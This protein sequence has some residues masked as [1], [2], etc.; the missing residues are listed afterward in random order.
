MSEKQPGAV[1]SRLPK[2]LKN[3]FGT[4]VYLKNS[5]ASDMQIS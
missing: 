2:R 4:L 5:L 3:D 1:E